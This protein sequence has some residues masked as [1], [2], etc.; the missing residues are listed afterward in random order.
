MT[1]PTHWWQRTICTYGICCSTVCAE[2]WREFVVLNLCCIVAQRGY[3]SSHF[4]HKRGSSWEVRWGR[5]WRCSCWLMTASCWE[6]AFIRNGYLSNSINTSC[7]GWNPVCR[8]PLPVPDTLLNEDELMVCIL[9]GAAFIGLDIFCAWTLN[10][11]YRSARLI[12]PQ[13][14]VQHAYLL[15]FLLD[16]NGMGLCFIEI[17]TS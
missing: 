16:V 12:V 15:N 10:T 6:S 1:N 13:I 14:I 8:V 17:Q 5:W 9:E 11:W 4:G 7:P 3:W 2:V